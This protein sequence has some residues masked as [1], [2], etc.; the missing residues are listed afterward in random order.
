MNSSVVFN[1][2]SISALA[3]VFVVLYHLHSLFPDY[4]LFDAFQYLY[5]GVDIFLFLSAFGLC[6]SYENNGIRTFYYRRFARIIPLFVVYAFLISC[7]HLYLGNEFS[8]WD[9]L[10]NL[11]GLSYYGLGGVRI[12][13][14]ISAL[15]LFYLFFPFLH[16]CMN[17]YGMKFLLLCTIICICVSKFTWLPWYYGCFVF[18]I[19]VF[20]Y[21]IY[22]FKFGVKP[23]LEL[24]FI[25]ATLMAIS[26][27]RCE[28]LVS[29]LYTPLLVRF[30]TLKFDIQSNVLNRVIEFIGLNTLEIYLANGFVMVAWCINPYSSFYGKLLFYCIVQVA[31]FGFLKVLSTLLKNLVWRTC[32]IKL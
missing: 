29:A 20:L 31:L 17:K 27:S 11:S 3:I 18:R 14:Y 28:F 7:F 25:A 32:I 13:W 30:F 1:K 21:G 16:I 22:V 4:R 15:L 9:W 19:P 6:Y 5:V 12:S 23:Q 24:F 26:F 10:C 8:L 2:T